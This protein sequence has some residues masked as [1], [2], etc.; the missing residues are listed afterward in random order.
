MSVSSNQLY[1]ISQTI[2]RLM[3]GIY[4]RKYF[5]SPYNRLV[6]DEL[7]WETGR[8]APVFHAIYD[9]CEIIRNRWNML[10]GRDQDYAILETVRDKIDVV[11]EELCTAAVALGYMESLRSSG[12]G[13]IN[14]PY[15]EFF[16]IKMKAPGGICNKTYQELISV[17]E[18]LR[19][20]CIF[21]GDTEENGDRI[22][23]TLLEMINQEYAVLTNIAFLHG[24]AIGEENYPFWIRKER[25]TFYLTKFSVHM[26]LP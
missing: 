25:P 14:S 22:I 24:K 13:I 1:N 12:F 15:E 23:E 16:S 20:E 4:D 9:E 7:D 21:Y 6:P 11:L 2:Y 8:A 17:L 3:T 18:S 5:H 19:A 10:T 26:Y